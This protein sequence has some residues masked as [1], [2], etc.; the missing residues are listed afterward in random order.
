MASRDALG[1]LN[2]LRRVAAA[3]YS[4]VVSELQYFVNSS[5]VKPENDS[6]RWSGIT[7]DLPEWEPLGEDL[8]HMYSPSSSTTHNH[9]S[10]IPTDVRDAVSD[11]TA[12]SL[13]TSAGPE[14]VLDAPSTPWPGAGPTENGFDP[15]VP[16]GRPPM[17]RAY[18]TATLLRPHFRFRSFHT[19]VV[20]RDETV[21][22]ST[23]NTAKRHTSK[24]AQPTTANPQKVT[25][26]QLH[27][28]MD[29]S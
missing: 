25:Y 10:A 1:V 22:G 16:S 17:H 18:H 9:S 7:L 15:P 29:L 21:I 8:S 20:H 11:L 6:N 12:P 27:F 2:G 26:T 19:S 24:D 23:A 3:Y 5:S 14:H 28:E 4:E 13:H